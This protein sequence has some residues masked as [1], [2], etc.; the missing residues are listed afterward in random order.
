MG[1]ESNGGRG[2]PSEGTREKIGLADSEGPKIHAAVVFSGVVR[3]R[4]VSPANCLRGNKVEDG[5]PYDLREAQQVIVRVSKV[6]RTFYDITNHSM[7]CVVTIW[8]G[9]IYECIR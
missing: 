8:F 2:R 9:A 3:L 5:E 4:L 6:G 7:G 1:G